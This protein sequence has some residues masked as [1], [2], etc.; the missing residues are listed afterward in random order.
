MS[1][2]NE[3]ED[4]FADKNELFEHSFAWGYVAKFETHKPT[5]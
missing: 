3:E 5:K 2:K 4:G 1:N